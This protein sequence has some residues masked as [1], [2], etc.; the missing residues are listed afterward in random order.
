MQFSPLD[1]DV[2]DG[3]LD[4]SSDASAGRINAKLLMAYNSSRSL[5]AESD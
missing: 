1:L 4:P 2:G 3:C 5:T